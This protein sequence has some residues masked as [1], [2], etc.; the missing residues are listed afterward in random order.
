M[1]SVAAL[2]NVL[3]TAVFNEIGAIDRIDH[4]A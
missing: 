4:R 1:A 3:K 2:F